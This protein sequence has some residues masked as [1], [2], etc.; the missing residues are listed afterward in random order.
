MS[1]RTLIAAVFFGLSAYLAYSA[2]QSYLA[3]YHLMYVIGDH[4]AAEADEVLFW[5]KAIP[6]T[7]FGLIGGAIMYFARTHKNDNHS[8]GSQLWQKNRDAK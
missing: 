7:I 1:T 6:A 5:L 4:S 8:R 3:W 2:W